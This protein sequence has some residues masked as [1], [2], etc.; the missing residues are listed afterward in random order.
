[1]SKYQLDL[2]EFDLK[3]LQEETFEYS[4]H[5]DFKKLSVLAQILVS[6]KKN[7]CNK[8]HDL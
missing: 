7:A 5:D 2:I 3:Y 1:M 4:E 6:Y 8:S